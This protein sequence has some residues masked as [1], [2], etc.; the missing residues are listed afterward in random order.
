MAEKGGNSPLFFFPINLYHP[1]LLEEA[2]LGL[3]YLALFSACLV[4]LP[5]ILLP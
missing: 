4:L 3:T 5:S 1:G 2:R